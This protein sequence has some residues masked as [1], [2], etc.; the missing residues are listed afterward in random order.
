MIPLSAYSRDIFGND[1]VRFIGTSKVGTDTFSQ[2][3]SSKQAIKFDHVAL[4]MHPFGF[5]GIEPGARLW[6]Q[7]GQNPNAVAGLL[8]LLVVLADPGSHGLALMPGGIIPD[9]EPVGLAL[10]KQTFT[11]PLQELDGDGAHRAADPE[12]QP[13]LPPVSPGGTPPPPRAPAASPGLGRLASPF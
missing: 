10:F 11:A 9:Q 7:E 8:D 6:Q 1:K 5:D 13:S 3:A 2:L 12:A 4:G